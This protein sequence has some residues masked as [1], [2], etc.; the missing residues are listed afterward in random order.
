MVEGDTQS[1]IGQRELQVVDLEVD[2]V[3]VVLI[4]ESEFLSERVVIVLYQIMDLDGEGS[5]QIR[6]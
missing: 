6:F 4:E 5:C 2:Q 1:L 3:V